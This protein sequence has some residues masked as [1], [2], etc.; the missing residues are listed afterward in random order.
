MRV[1]RSLLKGSQSY[2]GFSKNVDLS[3]A[4]RSKISGSTPPRN[5]HRQMN[6]AEVAEK[7]ELS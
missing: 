2:P 3:L 6:I 5:K 4:S 7:K 1:P